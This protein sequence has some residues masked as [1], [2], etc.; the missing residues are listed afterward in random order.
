MTK[1]LLRDAPGFAQF[2]TQLSQAVADLSLALAGERDAE[3]SAVIE[4]MRAN[5]KSKL[6]PVLGA[7]TAS[8]IADAF[9]GVVA[10]HKREIER[11]CL[12]ASSRN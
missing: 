10:G 2:A 3:V 4:Q 9:V 8:E 7:Q 1:L 5:L 6:A 12:S 11:R